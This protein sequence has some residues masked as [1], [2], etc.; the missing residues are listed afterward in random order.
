[1]VVMPK[2][3]RTDTNIKFLAFYNLHCYNKMAENKKTQ[4]VK[5]TDKNIQ[6]KVEKILKK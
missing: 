4:R 6:S 2:F 5:K 3:C 1:M